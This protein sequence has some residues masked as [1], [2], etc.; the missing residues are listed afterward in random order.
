MP[1]PKALF[2]L[3]N[4]QTVK[5]PMAAKKKSNLSAGNEQL[6]LQNQLC[7]ALHSASRAVTR[8]YAPILKQHK[9]TYPQYLALMVLWQKDGQSIQSIADHLE[10]DQATTT[11]L[12]QRLEK[13]GFVTR[14]RSRED[15]R[16]VEVWLTTT[17]KRMYKEAGEISSQIVCG[18]GISM[19]EAVDIINKMKAVKAS[20][21]SNQS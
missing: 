14:E 2:N 19:E 9:L 13:L 6:H 1:L 8:L 17:G 4:I 21:A 18:V 3:F 15:E 7:F 5:K 10:I 11:P 16:R 20:I 12:L